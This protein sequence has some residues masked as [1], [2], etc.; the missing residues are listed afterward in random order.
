MCVCIH[1]YTY[2]CSQQFFACSVSTLFSFPFTLNF[3]QTKALIFEKASPRSYIPLFFLCLPIFSIPS[4]NL[5]P[6][7]VSIVA[8]RTNSHNNGDAHM[9]IVRS[10]TFREIRLM[11]PR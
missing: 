11:D 7:L 10:R 1:I 4:F 3:S 9:D 2:E 6:I 5:R 8:S